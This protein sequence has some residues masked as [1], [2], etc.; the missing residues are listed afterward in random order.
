MWDYLKGNFQAAVKVDSDI[1][2]SDEILVRY[3]FR[4]HSQMPEWEQRALAACRGR[5]LDIGAGAGGHSLA[6]QTDGLEVVAMD[7]SPGAVSMMEHR[8]VKHVLH[9]SIWDFP[10]DNFDTLLMMMNGIGLVGD[11]KG[12][13]RFLQLAPQWLA[14]G[15]QILLDSSDI[16][17]LFDDDQERIIQQHKPYYG[18]IN[19]QM[20]YGKVTSDPFDWMY[21]D[22][23]R[24]ETHARMFGFRAEKLYDGPHFEYLARLVM[25]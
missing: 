18:I 14:P 20:S 25:L 8:G 2:I 19:Y 24:L 16:R 11:L 12:L 1:A 13:N 10:P 6:L 9:Q 17:Y 15:G 4:S 22:F 3:L 23:A 5:V 7:V 21:V